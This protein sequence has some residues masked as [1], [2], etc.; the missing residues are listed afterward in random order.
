[1]GKYT[2]GEW[3]INKDF[4][5]EDFWAINMGDHNCVAEVVVCME[6]E[7][8]DKVTRVRLEANVHLMKTAPKLYEMLKFLSESPSIKHTNENY[9]DIIEILKEARGED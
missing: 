6:G 5:R 4:Y 8:K 3:T 1:M 2:K 7:E 9:D